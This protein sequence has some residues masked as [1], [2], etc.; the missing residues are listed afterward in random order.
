MAALNGN[1]TVSAVTLPLF[2]MFL[3]IGTCAFVVGSHMVKGR[4]PAYPTVSMCAFRPASLEYYIF[5]YGLCT[6]ASLIMVTGFLIRWRFWEQRTTWLAMLAYLASNVGAVGLAVTSIVPLQPDIMEVL[7]L[8]R[9]KRKLS[10]QSN[11]HST[12]AQFSTSQSR[13]SLCATR[14]CA[15]AGRG[16]GTAIEYARTC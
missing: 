10:L 5:A 12:G 14:A 9:A 1:G 4:E 11:I 16:L 7:A 15:R 6:C 13:F 8:P 3:G 2:A